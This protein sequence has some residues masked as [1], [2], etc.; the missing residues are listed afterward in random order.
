MDRNLWKLGTL[1][2]LATVG[3]CVAA[4]DGS[5]AEPT[6]GPGIGAADSLDAADHGC[7]VVLRSAGAVGDEATGHAT[8]CDEDGCW[9][10]FAG[11]LDVAVSLLDEGG[12]PAVLFRSDHGPEWWSVAAERAAGAGVGFRRF[13]FELSSRTVF[14][15]PAAARLPDGAELELIPFVRLAD[16][17]RLFDHNRWSGD[18]VNHEL[19]AANGWSVAF[20]PSTCPTGPDPA[21]TTAVVRFPAGGGA[22]ALD[23]TLVPGGTLRVSYAVERLPLRHT[24]NGHPCWDLQAFVLFD[25]DVLPYVSSVNSI[26]FE[27][28]L[29]YV[30]PSERQPLLVFEVRVPGDAERVELW[31]RNYTGCDAPQEAWDSDY[32]ANYGFAI[33]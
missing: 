22:P 24:H 15:P 2:L 3:G 19:T 11:E 30:T 13:R 1:L 17:G 16:G 29:V 32:G 26:A 20:D 33:D 18:L 14:A 25:S 21:A 31:F 12:R 6:V 10:V 5:P 27:P 4:D 28:E 23:G 7:R 9:F 8:R